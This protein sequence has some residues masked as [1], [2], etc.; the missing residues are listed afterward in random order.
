[1]VFCTPPGI[2]ETTQS[3]N[4]KIHYN[5]MTR[6][7]FGLSGPYYPLDLEWVIAIA[8]SKETHLRNLNRLVLE[9]E[10][11]P[12]SLDAPPLVQRAL[13]HARIKS[14]MLLCFNSLPYGLE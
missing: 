6:P 14:S 3:S 9:D 8:K 10:H 12:L 11:L 2:Y 1:M 5:D 7:D 4:H 13:D